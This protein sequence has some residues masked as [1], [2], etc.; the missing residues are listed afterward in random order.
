MKG[1][2]PAKPGSDEHQPA[3]HEPSAH[4]APAKHSKTEKSANGASDDKSEHGARAVK[5][6]RATDH[7]PEE[8]THG[9]EKPAQHSAEKSDKHGA[10]S[11]SSRPTRSAR[12]SRASKHESADAHDSADSHGSAGVPATDGSHQKEQVAKV[13]STRPGA[14]TSALE[15]S[16]ERIN[17]K[18]EA[19]KAS[20]PSP[21]P[22]PA[23][24]APARRAPRKT[25]T[26]EG[27]TGARERR[28]FASW[29]PAESFRRQHFRRRCR[30]YS[31]RWRTGPRLAD[32]P[33][34]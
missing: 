12:A 13:V 11:K 4:E 10:A 27:S 21:S 24:R 19:I 25:R 14:S 7:K 30:A 22:A 8:D 3:V 1:E 17:A 31:L 6:A 23:K 5:V 15:E 34:Q 26:R 16:M 33:A 32:G 2:P 9:A 29:S 20:S 28:R 18:V